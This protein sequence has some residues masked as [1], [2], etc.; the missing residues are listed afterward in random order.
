VVRYAESLEVTISQLKREVE[1]ASA[2][3]SN[4]RSIEW[5][6]NSVLQKHGYYLHGDWA[7]TTMR[8]VII[9]AAEQKEASE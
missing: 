2:L 7:G 4:G 6:W 5:G 1:A 8:D 9:K 3:L